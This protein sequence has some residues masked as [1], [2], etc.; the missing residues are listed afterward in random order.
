MTQSDKSKPILLLGIIWLVGAACDRIWFAFDHDI[1]A[2]DQADYLTGTLNYWQALQNPQWFSPQWWTSF[3]QI[4]TK[5]PPLTY[6]ATAIIQN[7]FGRGPDQATI[8][9]LFFSAILLISVY[10]L[11]EKLFNRQV[12]LW[13]AF[14]CQVLPALYRYRLDFLLDYPVTAVVTLS[15]YCLTLWHLKKET[16]FLKETS[17]STPPLRPSAPLLTC[18]SAWFLA[19]IF[20]LSLGL[21]LMVKQT[22]LL[23]LLTPILWVEA[24][25]IR[26]KA[27][28]KIGQLIGAGCVSV[29]L[30]GG[31]YRT[32][33][34]L[35]L[36]SGKRATIDSAIAEGDPALNTIDAWI[37]Y[38]KILP[39]LVSW[40]LLLVPIVG[41]LLYFWKQISKTESIFKFSPAHPHTGTLASLKWLAIFLAGGYLLCS[42]NINKDA[43]YILPL[44]PV[45]SILLAYGL[46]LWTGRF[47]KQ[48]RWGT[49]S[50]A[51]ILML[52][53]LWPIGGDGITKILSPRVQHYAYLGAEWPHQQV[54][55]EIIKT[56]PDLQ[57]TLGVLPSTPQ[58]NQH[59]FNYYGALAN[60]QVY[61]RQVGTRQKHLKQDAR[62]LSW[63]VTK[64]GEQGSIPK[65]Q[66]AMVQLIEKGS[67]FELHKTWELPDKST[68]KLYHRRQPSVVVK[69]LSQEKGSQKIR[70]NRVIVPDKAP[71]GIP[72]PVTYEWSSPSEQLR[73][74]LLLL[75]WRK[76][77]VTPEKRTQ[78]QRWL[79]DHAI[80]MGSLY[81]GT[82]FEMGLPDLETTTKEL[83]VIEQTAMLP[84]GNITPGTYTLEAAYFNQQTGET[85]PIPV[86]PVTLNI[87]PKA[88]PKPAPELDLV[89][90]LRIL[91][92]QLPTGPKALESLFDQI[93]RI[94]QYDPIQDYLEQAAQALEYRLKREPQ[95]LE[96]AY[97]VALARVLQQRVPDA[98]AALQRVTQL[99]SQNP[100]AFAY[101]AFVNLYDWRPGAAQ[102][103]LFQ[104]RSLNPNFPELDALSAVAA[105]MQGNLLQAWH[106]FQQLT[107]SKS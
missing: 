73:T 65:T 79:H 25:A 34:L 50:L 32:N 3:W 72:V 43:R 30:A 42:L 54:I 59:N 2:W 58:I 62:S 99:D 35:I 83:R 57:S 67:D 70:L 107:A 53:N 105:L 37:Y 15:F 26:Q 28:G 10:G 80:A 9:N 11:G 55:A 41:I 61:G 4:T 51:V 12:G 100:Y 68:L 103:A 39:Y 18:P 38:W 36:T 84:P 6:I 29:L 85:Y 46:T 90:Q 77:T 78:P 1:P 47:S 44:L 5:V 96:W 17:D 95:N 88:A 8:V 92:A 45:V 23:F 16:S 7:L 31:W 94:N 21:A 75:T 22:A 91:S 104:A 106:H 56:E 93:G 98:I 86:P 20:G 81:P 27:W 60:F 24:G 102:I 76:S 97:G 101:L 52:L 48:I 71:P 63:F 64:T 69:P 19:G 49:A 89:T 13:A 74:G 87:D 14:L 40:P 33:W 66:P 82:S